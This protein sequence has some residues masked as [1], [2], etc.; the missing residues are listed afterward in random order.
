MAL[1]LTNLTN[2]VIFL[3]SHSFELLL[4]HGIFIDYRVLILELVVVSFHLV[5]LS[6]I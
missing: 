2:Q 1:K 6:L 4:H 3:F 5:F